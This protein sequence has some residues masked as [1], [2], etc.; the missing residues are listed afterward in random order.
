[1]VTVWAAAVVKAAVPNAFIE[2][3]PQL[4][5]ELEAMF[6]VAAPAPVMSWK[7]QLLMVVL[8]AVAAVIVLAVPTVWAEIRSL[9]IAEL[10]FAVK[11]PETVRLIPV[12]ICSPSVFVA[13]PVLVKVVQVVEVP[14][15]KVPAPVAM[16]VPKVLPPPEKV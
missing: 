15:V 12:P 9:L 14:T 1:M 13:V 16:I 11:V 4:P 2:L 7:S 6:Q 8:S 10:P 3:P 5:T